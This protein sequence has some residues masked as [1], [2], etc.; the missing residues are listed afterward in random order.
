[1]GF[2]PQ[3]KARPVE[4][5]SIVKAKFLQLRQNSVTAASASAASAAFKEPTPALRADFTA[6][7]RTPIRSAKVHA[8]PTPLAAVGLGLV[9]RLSLAYVTVAI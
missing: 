3:S 4:M 2:S 5:R 1:M 9:S 8:D 6:N 7:D